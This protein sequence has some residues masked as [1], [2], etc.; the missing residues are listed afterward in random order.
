MSGASVEAIDTKE[1]MLVSAVKC[2]E[3]KV[4]QALLRYIV[5]VASRV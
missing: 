3:I 5:L 4:L 2:N 1:F